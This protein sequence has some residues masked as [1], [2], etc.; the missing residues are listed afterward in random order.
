MSR[1]EVVL[2]V[3]THVL[4]LLLLPEPQDL[5]R[6]KPRAV[7]GEAVQEGSSP[8]EGTRTAYGTRSPSLSCLDSQRSDPCAQPQA[9]PSKW[10]HEQEL[11]SPLSQ[12]G[13]GEELG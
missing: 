10:K 7:N 4:L 9:A 12:L 2:S 5:P 6:K 3:L 8:R 11:V 1:P 13:A